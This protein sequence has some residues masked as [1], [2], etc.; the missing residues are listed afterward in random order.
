MWHAFIEDDN[1]EEVAKVINASNVNTLE[2]D[3]WPPLFWAI[4]EESDKVLDYLIQ[5]GADVNHEARDIDAEDYEGACRHIPLSLAIGVCNPYAFKALIRAGADI[6]KSTVVAD[7]SLTLLH[8]VVSG[9]SNREQC[10]DEFAS[11]LLNLGA[12]VNALN[13]R[14]ET[15]LDLSLYNRRHL[16]NLQKR[17]LL[18]GGRCTRTPSFGFDASFLRFR[19]SL[20]E[21]KLA[22]EAT[23][24]ALRHQG[25][26]HKDIVDVVAN[27][28]WET[29]ED[30]EV[31][32][33]PKRGKKEKI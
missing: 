33:P 32:V 25:K 15:P 21:C 16:T 10:F 23:R 11:T 22:T 5:Q 28:V 14:G 18:A 7:H 31:W 9:P 1:V 19:M 3:E 8:E 12:N 2:H 27:M 20:S 24:R 26:I 17:L 30:E 29:K 13:H 6:T 4:C